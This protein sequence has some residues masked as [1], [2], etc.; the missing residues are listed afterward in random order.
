MARC[1]PWF[2]EAP[3]FGRQ[4]GIEVKLL[5]DTAG[6]RV[7]RIDA[8][9]SFDALLTPAGL[10]ALASRGRVDPTTIKRVAQVGIDLNGLF[11][12]V[13][14]AEAVR[15]KAV[16]VPGGLVAS[17]LVSGKADPAVHPISQ[18]LPVAGVEWVAPLPVSI[19]NYTSDGYGLPPAGRMGAP[20]AAVVAL[21][22]SIEAAVIIR[23]KDMAALN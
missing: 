4:S 22:G 11:Q 3:E 12:R 15:A 14:V 13:G 9:E 8:G 6:A 21:F 5:N 7:K 2:H 18:I 19:Q 10:E 20:E 1:P 17:R 16:L 23:A